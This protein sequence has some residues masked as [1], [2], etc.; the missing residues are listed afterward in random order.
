MH[1]DRVQN[2]KKTL[3]ENIVKLKEFHEQYKERIEEINK[4][5]EVTMKEK[6]LLKLE[7]DKFNT[8]VQ[9]TQKQI[10][11]VFSLLPNKART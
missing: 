11:E 6:T 4:K 7:R 9:N 10:K 1:Y 8:K 2:E 3:S 5:Y